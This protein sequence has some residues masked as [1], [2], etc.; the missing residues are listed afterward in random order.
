MLGKAA[1]K[2]GDPQAAKWFELTRDLA[3]TGFADPLGLAADSYGWEGRS[4]WK[5]NHPAKAA[6]LFLTQLALGDEGAVVSLK[7]LIPDR[8]PVDGFVTYGPPSEEDSSQWNDERRKAEAE[9]RLVAF[10]EAAKD[11]LLRQLVTAHTLP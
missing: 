5:Q 4:E 1:L 2:A 3:K 9:K 7:A 6:Q 10:K 8:L 11:P